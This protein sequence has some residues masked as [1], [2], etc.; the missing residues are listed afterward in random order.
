M[1]SIETTIELPNSADEDAEWVVHELTMTFSVQPAEP[2]VGISQP[3]VE[4]YQYGMSDGSPVPSDVQA[5][6]DTIDER[7]GGA[8]HADYVNCIMQRWHERN[9]DLA[10]EAASEPDWSE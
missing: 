10:V 6:L 8:W 7:V 4:D 9:L 1:L 5:R 3:F 2:D